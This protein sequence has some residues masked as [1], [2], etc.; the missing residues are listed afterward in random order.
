MA[1][2][3]ET[4][5]EVEQVQTYL[6]GVAKSL[7]DRLYGA[8]GPAWG[9]KMSQLEDVID[10]IRQSLSEE[11]LAEALQRQA[12]TVQDSPEEFQTCPGC[13]RALTPLPQA[14]PRIVLTRVGE[15]QWSEPED[16]CRKC[17]RSFFPSVQELGDGS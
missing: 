9:T 14:E 17:R 5:A 11:M 3:K 10:A 6:H 4:I 7:V 16:Y 2:N 13:G 1:R 15:A 12:K 8:N